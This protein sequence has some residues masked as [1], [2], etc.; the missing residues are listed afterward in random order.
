MSRADLFVEAV[1][2][3][4]RL[5]YAGAAWFVLTAAVATLALYAVAVIAWTVGRAVWKAARRALGGR[6]SAEHAPQAPEPAP[7][8]QRRTRPS[9]AHEQPI[10]YEEAV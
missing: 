7:S 4:V 5:F 9:W 1:D 2:I 3:A 6:R 8:P 10:D